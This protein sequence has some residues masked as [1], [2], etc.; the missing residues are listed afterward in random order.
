[1]AASAV[2]RPAEAAASIE[3]GASLLAEVAGVA[4]MTAAV[5]A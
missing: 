5:A 3:A 2:A 1:V 4:A